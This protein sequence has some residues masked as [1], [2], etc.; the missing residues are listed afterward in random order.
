[1]ETRL[2][3]SIGSTRLLK[4]VQAKT[5]NFA[6]KVMHNQPQYNERYYDIK[7]FWVFSMKTP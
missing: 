6:F 7:N 2:L 1:M 4:S 3:N 5:C